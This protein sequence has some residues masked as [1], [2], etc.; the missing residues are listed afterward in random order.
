MPSSHNCRSQI[1]SLI[2]EI[3]AGIADDGNHGEEVSP[4][5]ACSQCQ[6]SVAKVNQN[7]GPTYSQ[8][9]YCMMYDSLCGLHMKIS[10]GI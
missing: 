9:A 1:S 10:F 6:Q 3:A 5:C 2:C 7:I 4:H 8:Q